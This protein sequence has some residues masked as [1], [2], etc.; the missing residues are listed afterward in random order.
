MLRCRCDSLADPENC[1]GLVH[2]PSSLKG[3]RVERSVLRI[4]LPPGVNMGT[5]QQ[6]QF[7]D[8]TGMI[9]RDLA[10]GLLRELRREVPCITGV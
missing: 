5:P 7:G 1:W 9:S 6:E 2:S 4:E 10:R 8:Q 3:L